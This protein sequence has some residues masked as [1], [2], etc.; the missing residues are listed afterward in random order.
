MT[1]TG[2]KNWHTNSAQRV[3]LE[4]KADLDQGLDSSDAAQ[5]LVHHG[6]NE[7]ARERSRSI[8]SHIASQFTDTINVVLLAAA[9]IGAI[10]GEVEDALAI[11]A[12]VL[13]NGAVGAL[14]SVRAEQALAELRNLGAFRATVIRGGDR[15]TVPVSEVVPGDLALLEA[16]ARVPA[17]M[18]LT[19]C[20][21]LKI[22]EAALTGESLPVD[23]AV[24]TLA[25]VHA[26]LA[27]RTNMAYIGTS[28]DYGRGSGI[29]VATGM[30]TD[31]GKIAALLK[32]VEAPRTPLQKR[33]AP[34]GRQLGIAIAIMCLGFFAAGIARGESVP[35]MLLTSISLA[36]AAIPE[37]LPTVLT[38]MLALG[39]R[40]LARRCALVRK[41]SAIETIGSVSHIC[42]DK[43]GTLTLN[44]MHAVDFAPSGRG[45]M[46]HVLEGGVLDQE[47]LPLLSAA[48]SSCNSDAGARERL[49]G[50]WLGDPTEVAIWRAAVDAAIDPGTFNEGW[51]RIIELPF[52]SKRM[53]MTVV[54]QTSEGFTAYM[55]G[56]PEAIVAR[57]TSASGE[58]AIA[59]DRAA[60]LAIAA[61]MAADGER[62][63]AVSK[64]EWR[65]SPLID[66][67]AEL[68]ETGH[69][70]LGFV[71]MQDP[72][73]PNARHAVD[74]CKAAGIVPVMITGDHPVTARAIARSL[75][76][77]ADDR[78][79]LTGPELETLSDEALAQKIGSIGVFARLDPSQKIRIVQ[80]LQA[81]GH[82]VAVT[83]DGINDAP[84]LTRAGIGVAMGMRGTDVAREAASIVLL[85]DDFST[86]VAGIKEGRRIYDNIRKFVRYALTCNTAELCVVAVAPFL[87]LPLPLLP[88]QILWINLVTDGLPGLALAAEPA[89]PDVMRRSPRATGETLFAARMWAAD[90]M[91]IDRHVGRDAGHA[92]L[93]FEG[94]ISRSGKP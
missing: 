21:Q 11:V 28:V 83:G 3:A 52:D 27:E 20:V 79:V 71:G 40:N 77:V 39:A 61:L 36:V 8:I 45:R 90:R 25:D 6:P 75:G 9:G 22:S 44:E 87:G 91:G 93:C 64:R 65:S 59:F 56:A 48:V 19:A 31:L 16:G 33:L 72:P 7:T 37:A 63:L 5:R 23:K 13:L 41:P 73:R 35:L 88:I 70:L 47:A 86:I 2:N 30:E 62:V 76:I 81:R 92:S 67:D 42:T 15:M 38:I 94:R 43:T 58:P 69:T 51:R 29:V 34:F 49:T 57:C 24:A 84:A 17:D 89:E 14:Q 74:V 26:S 53:R 60:R 18:R 50:R 46:A 55:K 78:S 85:D 10:T 32:N 12:L 66:R 54:Y 1:V 82:C 80:A 4:L 68:V